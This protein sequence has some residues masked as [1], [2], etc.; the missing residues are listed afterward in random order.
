MTSTT[1]KRSSKTPQHRAANAQFVGVA[2][3]KRERRDR[4]VWSCPSSRSDVAAHQLTSDLDG[5]RAHCTC[6]AFAVHGHCGLTEALPELV[7]AAL[8][9]YYTAEAKRMST[10][11]LRQADRGYQVAVE[12]GRPVTD[13]DLIRWQCVVDVLMDRTFGASNAA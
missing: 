8:P 3:L 4:L 2:H 11:D 9:P 12:R 7:A 6:P 13:A 5:Q 10:Y 1:V